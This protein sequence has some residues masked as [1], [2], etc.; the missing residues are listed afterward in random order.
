MALNDKQRRFVAEYLIDL[1]A[2]QAAIR[3]GYSE[4]TAGSQGF[5]LLKKPEIQAWVTEEMKA[6][7][8]RTEITQDRVLA[9]LAKI[10]FADIRRAVKW[11]DGIAVTDPESGA[12]EISNGVALIGSKE[13]D[14]AT[15]ASISEVSQTAQGIKIKMHDKR[16]AL[17]DIGRHLGM[18]TDKVEHTGKDGGPIETA[19]VTTDY[20]ALRAQI[21]AKRQPE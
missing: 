19:D 3:A 14:D 8:Q 16:A 21:D 10:G 20:K 2:T 4:R 13:I 6:R 18:F 1:N 12:V 17:V 9:E 5:D 11:G 7:E 15:A